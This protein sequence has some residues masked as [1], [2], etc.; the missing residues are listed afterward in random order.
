M[1]GRVRT[2]RAWRARVTRDGL[3]RYRQAKNGEWVKRWLELEGNILCS[4]KSSDKP[5]LLNAVNLKKARAQPSHRD[6][7]RAR[8]SSGRAR[9]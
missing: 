2:L 6:A 5:K 1:R 9:V 4:Y 3:F 8:E 7:A